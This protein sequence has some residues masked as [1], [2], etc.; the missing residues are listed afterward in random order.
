MVMPLKCD[1][2]YGTNL[3]PPGTGIL[4]VSDIE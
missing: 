1:D 3:Y 4:N 2:A